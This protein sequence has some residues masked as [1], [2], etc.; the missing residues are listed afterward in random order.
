MHRAPTYLTDTLPVQGRRPP[1][2]VTLHAEDDSLILALATAPGHA[3]VKHPPGP[4][5]VA[6]LQKMVAAEVGACKLGAWEAYTEL[7]G[8]VAGWMTTVQGKGVAKMA[9]TLAGG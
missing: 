3:A 2:Q 8:S 1:M 5:T 6:Q 7:D 9:E 4:A